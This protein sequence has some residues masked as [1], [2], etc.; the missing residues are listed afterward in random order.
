MVISERSENHAGSAR[1]HGKWVNASRVSLSPVDFVVLPFTVSV[2]A[3]SA[4]TGGTGDWGALA[5]PARRSAGAG[6]YRR[7]RPA[8]CQGMNTHGEAAAALVSPQGGDTAG[9]AVAM[10]AELCLGLLRRAAR[11]HRAGLK[12]YGLLVA[13]P[14]TAGYPFTAADVVFLDP[15]KNRRNDPG[16]RAAFRAQGEYFRQYDDAGFVA[17]PAELLAAWRAIED[18]GRQVVA[19]FHSH[20]RQPANFSLIDYR[21]HNPAFAWHLIISLRDPRHP[22]LQ[23]FRVHKELSDFGISDQDA[24]QGSELAYQGPE[25]Q[26]LALVARGAHQAIRRLTSTLAPAGSPK[27]ATAA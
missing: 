11:V 24:C 7:R 17:D 2:G 14:G 22:V 10:P 1:I 25:V 19:P 13:E 5:P 21:L 18:S 6:M 16:H 26:P 9:D 4:K 12:S 15:G 20:R 8:L 23:P 3:G 27:T